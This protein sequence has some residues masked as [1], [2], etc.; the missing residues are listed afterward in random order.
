VQLILLTATTTLSS[1]VFLSNGWDL[2]VFTVPS[3]A[4]LLLLS[5]VPQRSG[6]IGLY[7]GLLI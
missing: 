2:S 3:H 7:V 6:L 4:I 5:Y 1:L